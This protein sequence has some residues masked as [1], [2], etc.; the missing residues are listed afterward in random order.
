MTMWQLLDCPVK[1]TD[2]LESTFD[3]PDKSC[4]YDY[5]TLIANFMQKDYLDQQLMI[6]R[7]AYDINPSE[8]NRTQVGH[9]LVDLAIEKKEKGE[10]SM[11][12]DSVALA[13]EQLA[14]ARE[15]F[16]LAARLCTLYPWQAEAE[17]G[18]LANLAQIYYQVYYQD[19]HKKKLI[20]KQFTDLEKLLN[21][22]PQIS[23]I[24]R[25]HIQSMI[26]QYL[27]YLQ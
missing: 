20:A 1:Y 25:E 10:Q 2:F 22:R 14:A 3:F 11:A 24:T 15:I 6:M 27:K 7:E 17:V 19:K 13:L 18:N 12:I 23:A 16:S 5:H 9:A 8:T 21:E 4:R 26:V